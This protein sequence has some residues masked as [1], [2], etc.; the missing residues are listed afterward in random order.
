[1]EY[2]KTSTEVR[3]AATLKDVARESG[4]SINTVSLA[5]RDSNRISQESKEKI[6]Q[7]AERLGYVKNNIASSLRTGKSH[8]IAIITHDI[9][10]PYFTDLVSQIDQ[11]LAA[12]G[13]DL[14]FLYI[15]NHENALKV[16][17]F[18]H[19]LPAEAI[20]YFPLCDDR[21]IVQF[22]Q[23][24]GTP[25]L[26]LAKVN[27]V[28]APLVCFDD[29]KTGELAADYLFS[30]GHRSFLYTSGPVE[31]SAQADRQAGFL[32]GLKKHGVPATSVRLITSDQFQEALH[33]N[34]I[35]SL[36]SP[37][38]YTAVFSF[39]DQA[40]YY[41]LYAYRKLGIR[42]PED[43]SIIGCD[44]VCRY[45]TSRFPLSSIAGQQDDKHA[46]VIV[47][48]IMKQ[49]RKPDMKQSVLLPVKI[50]EEGT[51]SDKIKK[52]SIQYKK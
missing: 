51:V 17:Q 14:F 13:Y 12:K 29:Y 16:V 52:I 7:A 25:F 37:I 38:N 22:L 6:R 49:I 31:I 41:L 33:K 18:V 26:L 30:H 10:N 48:Q 2:H 1:M 43:I 5:L 35:V 23:S 11:L 45:D 42:V 3:K 32:D 39:N 44:H 8:I 24:S 28:T 27:D 36:V 9:Q 21:N 40:A 4:Y 19:F 46:R 15:N 47:Q 50:F 34:D 20:L